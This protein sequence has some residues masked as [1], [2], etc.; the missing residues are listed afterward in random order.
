MLQQLDMNCRRERLD[1]EPFA[2]L[3]GRVSVRAAAVRNSRERP[4][5]GYGFRLQF[6]H[7]WGRVR[8]RT[9]WNE[10]SVLVENSLLPWIYTVSLRTMRP[11]RRDDD[12]W[13]LASTD[14]LEAP[15]NSLPS[16]GYSALFRHAPCY[17]ARPL[18]RP[19]EA[20]AL[21]RTPI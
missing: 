19:P 9:S 2:L 12:N 20:P 18:A 10:A 1:I 13:L 16:R 6:G 7:G 8:C 17:P 11:E 4:S 3:Y 5:L 14:D 21:H 15:G